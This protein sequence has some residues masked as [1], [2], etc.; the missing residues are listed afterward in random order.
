MWMTL[1]RLCF[2]PSLSILFLW[3]IVGTCAS[4]YW[5]QSEHAAFEN[6]QLFPTWSNCCENLFV[7]SK[8]VTVFYLFC[9]FPALYLF[10]DMQE[11]FFFR[12][13]YF[14]LYYCVKLGS[15]YINYLIV[16]L[17]IKLLF[18]QNSSVLYLL[19][20]YVKKLIVFCIFSELNLLKFS[21]KKFV[22]GA[23]STIPHSPNIFWCV[24][25]VEN[26]FLNWFVIMRFSTW[27]VNLQEFSSFGFIVGGFLF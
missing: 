8:K 13:Y 14:I 27:R 12:S 23:I 18:S 11:F 5:I 10:S 2:T 24:S 19:F 6:I 3:I 26:W 1:F 20:A 25:F 4:K 7:K 16:F 21:L 9:R 17:L 22:H 15:K